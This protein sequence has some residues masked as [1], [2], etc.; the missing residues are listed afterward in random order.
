MASIFILVLCFLFILPQ[1]TSHSHPL[2][3]LY[4]SEISKVAAIVK[5]SKLGLSHNLSFHYVG[6]HEPSKGA[7]LS[8]LKNKTKKPPPRRAFVIARANEQNYEIIVGLTTHSIVSY[9]IYNGPGFPTPNGDE[10]KAATALPLTY[11][12]FIKSIKKRGIDIKHVVLSMDTKGWFGKS[13]RRVCKVIAL[14]YDGS[15]N[16]WV[17]PIEGITISVNLD[18]ME[19]VHYSDSLVV[20][21]PHAKGTEYRASEM[22][23]PFAA[24][25][26]PIN[27]VQ[28]NGPS[29]KLDGQEIRFVFILNI[30][31]IFMFWTCF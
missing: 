28:P 4:P 29:F 16:I 23:P 17:R 2:D 26:K 21:V 27:I 25:I 14:Y 31:T 24:E 1:N 13:D 11:P 18:K 3:S 8:W 7:V 30:F 20:T 15:P 19:I 12:P 10:D 9:R 5:E 6:L 22:K